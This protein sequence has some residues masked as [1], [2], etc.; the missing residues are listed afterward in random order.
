MSF[1]FIIKVPILVIDHVTRRLID[2]SH[3]R[4]ALDGRANLSESQPCFRQDSLLTVKPACNIYVKI[5][6][7]WR[8]RQTLHRWTYF[9]LSARLD[10][11]F[12]TSRRRYIISNKFT[13]SLKQQIQWFSILAQNQM[14]K[15]QSLNLWV[16]WV[17]NS[18]HHSGLLFRRVKWHMMNKDLFTR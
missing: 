17:R 10:F 12:F 13:F 7:I 18:F 11:G 8:G 9:V 1:H 14:T 16:L 3:A 5:I 15:H 2:A 6:G 4:R